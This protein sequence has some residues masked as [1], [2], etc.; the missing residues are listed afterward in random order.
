MITV[1]DK[2][3]DQVVIWVNDQIVE[4]QISGQVYLQVRPQLWSQINWWV[5]EQVWNQIND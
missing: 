2:I 5:R 1:I 4:K 3:K